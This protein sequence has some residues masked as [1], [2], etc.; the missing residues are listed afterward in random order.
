MRSIL[1]VIVQNPEARIQFTSGS[2]ISENAPNVLQFNSS[3]DVTGNLAVAGSVSAFGRNLV[4][5]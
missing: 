3:L 2:S 5:L 1:I 4:R